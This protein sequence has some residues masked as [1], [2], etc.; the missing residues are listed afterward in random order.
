MKYHLIAHIEVI[1]VTRGLIH[2]LFNPFIYD[3]RL[4]MSKLLL[5]YGN[6]V[7]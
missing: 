2:I 1:D 3:R 5:F 7:E 4:L 6:E